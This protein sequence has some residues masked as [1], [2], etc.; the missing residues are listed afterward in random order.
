MLSRL[1]VASLLVTVLV[2]LHIISDYFG[3]MEY[4]VQTWV[5]A[6]LLPIWSI[7]V[8]SFWHDLGRFLW[9]KIFKL[10]SKD[11]LVSI[12]IRAGV[13]IVWMSCILTYV[14]WVHMSLFATPLVLIIPIL[15][16]PF[17][18]YLLHDWTFIPKFNREQLLAIAFWAAISYTAYWLLTVAWILLRV[19]LLSHIETGLV[20]I[21][22]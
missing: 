22:Q 2:G 20:Y 7:G 10:D 18:E 21:I 3:D 8:I 15:A 5:G 1:A 13:F 9:T 19:F 11:S 12:D 4:P 17:R 16:I 6:F 14:V